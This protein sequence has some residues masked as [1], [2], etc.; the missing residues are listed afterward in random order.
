MANRLY[1]SQRIY[2]FERMAVKLMGSLTVTD[3]G[4]FAARV[5]QGITI[6][7]NT[8]GS[9]G[10][11]IT[12]A[13]TGGGT[14][15]SEVVTVSTY[16]ISVQIQS[17]VSTITQVRAAINA[18]GAA[19]ALV[20]AVGTSASTVATASALA[21]QNGD[22]TDFTVVGMSGCTVTQTGTGI[23]L[24]TLAN[25]YANLL[26]FNASI[27]RTAAVDLITQLQSVDT[28]STKKI[29]FRT[30]AA[31]TPTDLAAND[32]LYIDLTLRNSNQTP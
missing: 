32:I 8:M 18:S 1:T 27:L 15:G 14:A 20:T 21:L 7:A 5:T 31:A 29:Y 6:T 16:A 28:S 23:F 4:A 30:Q 22:D 17:G 11:S 9:L 2:N 10:N 25:P 19:A 3:V 12:I 24:I 13:F 26:T